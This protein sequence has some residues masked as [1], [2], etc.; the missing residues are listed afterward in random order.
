MKDPK[1]EEGMR[2]MF[3]CRR[4][5]SADKSYKRGLILEEMW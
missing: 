4:V 1:V 2:L 5:D 3:E